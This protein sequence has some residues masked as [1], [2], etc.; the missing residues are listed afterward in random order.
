MQ[1]SDYSILLKAKY[2]YINEND[3]IVKSKEAI[4][5]K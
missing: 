4:L 2:P 5:N 3:I 1:N